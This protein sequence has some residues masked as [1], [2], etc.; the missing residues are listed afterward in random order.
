MTWH[1]ARGMVPSAAAEA[2]FVDPF[3]VLLGGTEPRTAFVLPAGHARSVEIKT[4]TERQE[5]LEAFEYADIRCSEGQGGV[6]DGAF[7]K[8]VVSRTTLRH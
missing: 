8:V 5:G 3:G 4:V 7:M 6:I 1:V 2:S